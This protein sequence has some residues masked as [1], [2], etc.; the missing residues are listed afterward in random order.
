MNAL[1][2]EYVIGTL[3]AEE[4]EAFERQ[5]AQSKSMQQEVLFWEEHLMTLQPDT[6]MA[7]PKGT[8]ESISSKAFKRQNQTD[9]SRGHFDL[10]TLMK[11]WISPFL[12]GCAMVMIL[13]FT[14]LVPKFSTTT[15][16]ADYIAVLT[17]TDG[18]AVITALTSKAESGQSMWFKWEISS[19]EK[20]KSIQLWAKSKETGDVESLAIF[21]STNVDRIAID[22]AAWKL[23]KDAEFL[24]L[25]EEELGGSTLDKPSNNLIAK[26]FC[27]RF[28][29]LPG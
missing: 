12:A 19:I 2:F 13:T 8:W 6:Q 27:V 20:N 17:D 25:T 1:A 10:F 3:R 4:R 14:G 24:L 22:P 15:P 9:E 21:N 18:Q 5:L 28:S 16:N 11:H 26:G 7:P 23:I 29:P